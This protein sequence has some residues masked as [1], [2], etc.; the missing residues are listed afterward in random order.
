MSELYP[1][2]FAADLRGKP[3]GSRDLRP[4]FPARSP[5]QEPV[6]EAW[7]SFEQNR[8]AEGNLSGASLG[9]LVERFGPRLMGAEHRPLQRRSAGEA[10]PLPA[11]AY[12]PI[13]TKL[14]FITEKLSVQVHPDDAYALAHENGPGKTEMWYGVSAEPG[15]QVALGLKEPLPRDRLMDASRSGEI[16]SYLRWT[17]VR[18]GDVVFVPAGT[19]HTLGPGLTICEIQ[20]N[21]D[22]TYRFYDFG[23]RG[24]DGKPRAL[25]IEQAAAV[26][27]HDAARLPTRPMELAHPSIRRELLAGCS[28]FAAERLSWAG[29]FLY[30]PDR[31]RC[32]AVILLAGEGRIAGQRYRPGDF[33]LVPAHA[34]PFHVAASG[35]SVAIVAYQPDLA[36][37]R[38]EAER[39][40]AAEKTVALLE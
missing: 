5:E 7:F 18:T 21:S 24:V 2:R 17:P 9:E 23:R 1:L 26:I 13:L 28:Y 34:A 32:H 27:R 15:A 22:L 35:P 29:D 20:Q 3:W 36:R 30:M 4:F 14:L 39:S 10:E 11:A 33:F 16:E 6:G 8:V 40:G 19:V 31:G 37:L 38:A 25:H 12:F